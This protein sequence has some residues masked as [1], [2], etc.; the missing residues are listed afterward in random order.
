MLYTLQYWSLD[1][2]A[3]FYFELTRL[4]NIIKRAYEKA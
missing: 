2:S 4:D 1:T 3:V